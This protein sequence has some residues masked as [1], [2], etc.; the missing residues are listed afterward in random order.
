MFVALLLLH[1]MPIG[2]ILRKISNG[3]HVRQCEVEGITTILKWSKMEK[4]MATRD[5]MEGEGSLYNA[6][7]LGCISSMGNIIF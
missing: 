6:S 1:P 3:I 2:L 4:V 5:I 7:S